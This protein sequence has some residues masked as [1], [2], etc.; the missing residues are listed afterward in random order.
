VSF[1][2][3]K[4]KKVGKRRGKCERKKRKDKRKRGIET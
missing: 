2:E 3:K 1:G 4:M